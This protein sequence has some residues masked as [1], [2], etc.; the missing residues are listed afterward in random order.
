MDFCNAKCLENFITTAATICKNCDER[1]NYEEPKFYILNTGMN[2]NY[3]CNDTCFSAYKDKLKLCFCCQKKITLEEKL[4]VTFPNNT[5]L[6]FCSKLCAEFYEKNFYREPAPIPSIEECTKC[7][8]LKRVKMN[9][10]IGN[11]VYAFCSMICFFLIKHA[12]NFFTGEFSWVQKN[13]LLF[14]SK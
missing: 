5:E 4:S 14:I 12:C 13:K 10:L 1:I 8:E 2:I 9:L 7:G 3:F 6:D 11:H